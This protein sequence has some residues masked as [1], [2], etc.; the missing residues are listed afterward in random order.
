MMLSCL[1]PVMKQFDT[2]YDTYFAKTGTGG[3]FARVGRWF[4]E[5]F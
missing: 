1:R 3:Y 2:G 5:S 4:K